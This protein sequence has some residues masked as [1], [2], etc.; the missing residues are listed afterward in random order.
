MTL[1]PDNFPEPFRTRMTQ[2]E[3][4][5]KQDDLAGATAVCETVLCDLAASNFGTAGGLG[6]CV[7]QLADELHGK[8]KWPQPA[9][10]LQREAA[11]HAPAGEW[12]P[13]KTFAENLINFTIAVLSKRFA[14]PGETAM[15]NPDTPDR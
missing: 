7:G 2:A 9:A 13:A 3:D 15:G 12:K 1:L 11:R 4:R 6:E 14:V 8:G 5:L 10:A